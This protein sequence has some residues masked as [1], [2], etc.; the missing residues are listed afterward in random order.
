MDNQAKTKEYFK[1]FKEWQD[2]MYSPGEYLGGK[3]PP[4]VKYGS[5]KI[6]RPLAWFILL[7]FMILLLFSFF[8]WFKYIFK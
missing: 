4:I 1:D 7:P 8:K 2:R 6:L 3:M 5:R